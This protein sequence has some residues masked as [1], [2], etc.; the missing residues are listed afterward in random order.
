[1]RRVQDLFSDEGRM[2]SRHELTR[3]YP[4]V[5]FL[6]IYA[7]K[8]RI[9]EQWVHLHLS[10]DDSDEQCS[11]IEEVQEILKVSKWAYNILIQNVTEFRAPSQMKWESE[12]AIPAAF[13][14][15]SVYA[16]LYGLTDNI[17]LRWLQ[18]RIFHRILPT[19]KLLLK[20]GLTEDN[21]CSLCGQRPETISHIFFHVPEN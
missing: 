1:M 19:K 11:R 3:K 18:Y 5:S 21:I 14:W 7:I 10:N 6:S 13:P 9:P 20:Y 17:A 15:R 16:N 4:N 2:L 12:L 8:A